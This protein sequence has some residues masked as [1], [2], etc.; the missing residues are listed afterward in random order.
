MNRHIYNSQ[1]EKLAIEQRKFN[2]DPVHCLVIYDDPFPQGS[3]KAA[4]MLLDDITQR[5]LMQQIAEL[6]SQSQ[7][8]CAAK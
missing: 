8:A 7:A 1:G 6:Q 4:P 2:G 5:W 3:G